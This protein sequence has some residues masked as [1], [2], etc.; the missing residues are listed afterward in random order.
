MFLSVP[1]GYI[2]SPNVGIM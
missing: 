1:I 2:N